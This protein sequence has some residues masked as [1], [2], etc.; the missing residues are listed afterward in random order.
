MKFK[1]DS[2]FPFIYLIII[3]NQHTYRHKV[4]SI[5]NCLEKRIK[6][7]NQ[8]RIAFSYGRNILVQTVNED[9]MVVVVVVVVVVVQ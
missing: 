4:N 3:R 8:N 1:C 9:W 2:T 7:Q 5:E 6:N